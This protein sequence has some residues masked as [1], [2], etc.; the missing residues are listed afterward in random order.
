ML[1]GWRGQ[2]QR[3]VTSLRTRG[4]SETA[5]RVW[6]HLRPAA[7]A[8]RA[9]LWSPDPAI[10]IAFVP[11]EAPTASIVVPVF[12][13]WAHTHQCL[14]ALA[15]AASPVTFEVVLVDDAS[16]DET[17]VAAS[18]VKGLRYIR[19]EENGGFI[20]ACNDGAAEARGEFLVFLNNDTVPQPGWLEALLGTFEICSDVGLVGSQLL[21]SDGRLQEA[22][23]MIFSDASAGNYGRFCDPEDPRFGFVRDVDYCSGAAIAVRR[24]LFVEIG[25][26][27]RRYL[28]AYYEDADLAFEVRSR[29]LRV[30]YQ[31]A[32]R[33]MHTEGV[34]SGRDPGEGVKA[35]QVVNQG[36]FAAKW[37]P[38]LAS[39]PAPG[40]PDDVAA[41]HRLGPTVL[42]VESETPRPDVDSAS[43]RL[44]GIMDML[45]AAGW[46]VVFRTLDNA[47]A[48]TA[49]TALQ[50]C[51][52]EVCTGRTAGASR[53]GSVRRGRGSMPWWRAGTSSRPLLAPGYGSTPRKHAWSSTPSTSTSSVSSVWRS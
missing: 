17:P 53:G 21:A 35:H 5:R 29:G 30:V 26:F 42:I 13:K 32:S 43:V 33:I 46:H 28:P 12:G 10:P 47:W 39:H 11:V 14:L 16:T 15:Q 38:V 2:F 7:R 4:A 50:Q 48:G 41:R 34:S 31:P 19:R 27:D 52:V 25:G 37:T 22:G 51:G 1:S 44:F 9:A 3:A 8:A 18:G 23:G 45:T 6:L 49:S 24:S 40:T 20:S 36:V